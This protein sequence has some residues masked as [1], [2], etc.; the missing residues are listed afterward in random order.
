MSRIKKVLLIL[1]MIIT[2]FIGICIVGNKEI[3]AT[4]TKISQEL[5]SQ[6]VSSL[7]M[8]GFPHKIATFTNNGYSLWCIQKGVGVDKYMTVTNAVANATGSSNSLPTTSWSTAEEL[9]RTYYNSN[10]TRR[11][12][13]KMTGEAYSL[14]YTLGDK[15]NAQENQ[16]SLYVFTSS[17]DDII[18]QC[19]SWKTRTNLKHYESTGNHQEYD[20]YAEE[21]GGLA[22]EYEKFYYLTHNNNNND[23]NQKIFNYLNKLKNTNGDIIVKSQDNKEELYRI[24]AEEYK[25]I[26]KY[27]DIIEVSSKYSKI[28]YKENGTQINGEKYDTYTYKDTI[29][30][31]DRKNNYYILGPFNVDY[32]LNDSSN[33]EL[34]Y[35]GIKDITVYNQKMED[36]TSDK[37]KGDFHIVYDYDGDLDDEGII[38][39]ISYL[40][41]EESSYYFV[42]KAEDGSII[43]YGSNEYDYSWGSHNVGRKIHINN[44][45]YT[46]VNDY[47]DNDSATYDEH[48]YQTNNGNTA[49]FYK[50]E[51]IIIN[52]ENYIAKEVSEDENKYISVYQNEN[53]KNIKFNIFIDKQQGKAT[54]K[55]NDEEL[56]FIEKV[57]GDDNLTFIFKDNQDIE[58]EIIIGLEYSFINLN[59][60]IYKEEKLENGTTQYQY[61]DEQ[62]KITILNISYDVN[63]LKNNNNIKGIE[64]KITINGV[65][66]TKTKKTID[67]HPKDYYT[68]DKVSSNAIMVDKNGTG[69][70]IEDKEYFADNKGQ[71]FESG[72]Y[73]YIVVDRSK[74][75]AEDFKGFYVKIDFIYLDKIEGE[76]YKVNPTVTEYSYEH[77]ADTCDSEFCFYI[78]HTYR[79]KSKTITS[80]SA[81]T[82]GAYKEGTRYYKTYSI[83]L[84]SDRNYETPEI[85]I[86]KKADSGEALYG[87]KFNVRLDINGKDIFGN[88]VIKKVTIPTGETNQEGK[89][90]ITTGLLENA[91]VN[92]E[93]FYG[94]VKVSIEETQV[95][96]GFSKA[97]NQTM[98]IEFRGQAGRITGV[99]GN[100]NAKWLSEKN[101]ASITIYNTPEGKAKIQISKVN[102]SN[103]LIDKAY[104]NIQVAYT[105]PG[106]SEVKNDKITKYGNLIDKKYNVIKGQTT[107]GI[108]SITAQDF[109]KLKDFVNTSDK[110]DL[111]NYTGKITLRIVEVGFSSGYSITSTNKVITLVYINGELKEYT[112]NTN[113]NVTV[114]YLYDILLTEVNKLAKLNSNTSINNAL[115]NIKNSYV[116]DLLKTWLRKDDNKNLSYKDAFNWLSD[117]LKEN[118]NDKDRKTGIMEVTTEVSPDVVEIVV[119]DYSG[120]S[121][122]SSGGSSSNDPDP[123]PD[124]NELLMTVA[125]RV[126]LDQTTK[127]VSANESDGLL[128]TG[129]ELLSGVQ[130]TLRLVKDGS[131]AKLVQ[132]SGKIRTNPTITDSNGYYE[133]NGT[134]PFEEYYVEFKYNGIEYTNTT[135]SREKYNE[136]NWAIS[137]KGSELDTERNTLNNK[138][139]E[140]GSTGIYC[141]TLGKY[142]IPYDYYTIEGIYVEIAN[143]V[144]SHIITDK[145]YPDMETIY[146]EVI[147]NHQKDDSE[148]KSKIDYIKSSMINSYAGYYS[149]DIIKSKTENGT[150]PHTDVRANV[151]W[152][153]NSALTNASGKSYPY[154]GQLVTVLGDGQR[155]INLGLKER[156]STDLSLL[157]DIVETKVSMNGYDT[158]YGMNQAVSSYNQYIYE[159][160]YNYKGSK[161]NT[162]SLIS[163]GVAYYTD[164]EIEYYITYEIEVNNA[165]LTETA[166]T[167]IVDYYN[168]NFSWK[169]SYTTSKGN[170]IKGYRAFIDGDEVSTDI[171]KIT[172]DATGEGRYSGTIDNTNTKYENGKYKKLFI[173]F[174][175]KDETDKDIWLIDG[176]TLTIYLTFQMGQE[177]AKGIIEGASSILYDNIHT[178]NKTSGYSQ[179]WQIGNYAEINGYKTKGGYLDSDSR[180]GNFDIKKYEEAKTAYQEAYSDYVSDTKNAD[181]ARKLKFALGNLTDAREDDAWNVGLNLANTG[182]VRALTGSVWEAISE[183]KAN[184]VK[185]STDLQDHQGNHGLLT[186]V[187]EYGLEGITV[188]LVELE[189]GGVQ[190]VRAKTETHANGDYIFKSYIPGNYTVRFTYGEDKNIRGKST[191]S[192]GETLQVNGQYYQST[193]ANPT[194]DNTKYWYAKDEENGVHPSIRYSDAYDDVL[195]RVNQF[196][197]TI[198][199]TNGR[200]T[201]SDY[202]YDGV[203]EVESYRHK[204]TIYAY[205]STLNLEVEYISPEI[206]GNQANSDYKYEVTNV[207]FGLTPRA[208]ADL[209]LDKYVS[210]IKI[211]L[212]DG[213]L[214]LDANM[215]KEGNVTYLN[216]QI[217]RNAVIPIPKDANALLNKDGLIEV[218]YDDTLLNGATLEVTYT[219]TVSNDGEYDTI[220]YIYGSKKDE[221]GKDVPIAIAYYGEDYKILPSFE[222]SYSVYPNYTGYNV[223]VYHNGVDGVGNYSLEKYEKETPVKVRTAATNIVDYIDP[224]LNFTQTDYLGNPINTDWETTSTD[225]F[226]TERTAST[227]DLNNE[228]MSKYTTIIRATS[229]NVLHTELLPVK[230]QAEKITVDKNST[231]EQKEKANVATTTLTLSKLL[232]TSSTGTNDWIYSNLAEI[233]SIHNDVGRVT[234]I[235]GYDVEGKS[236]PETSTKMNISVINEKDT[237]YPTLET[238][239]SQTITIHPRTG[240][241]ITEEAQSN[242]IIILAV[243]V[244]LA[245]GIVLIKK[246]V[247]TKKE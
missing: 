108:L 27:K 98:T 121:G 52:N 240:L 66:Y 228:I 25:N 195:S 217:F 142:I 227:L 85:E 104:F 153:A 68:S 37:I 180:P 209:D 26:H 48:K 1:A 2:V 241:S 206:K 193:K 14:T 237:I 23:Y 17:F 7:W 30:E 42:Y 79:L 236:Q 210:N 160:D 134:D 90:N 174:N 155:Q 135:S 56:I 191:T 54:Y 198:V 194:T 176:K 19:A 154:A 171:Y 166:L 28:D 157:T 6:D 58:Y 172:I 203:L 38:N 226:N 133:F 106:K 62:G 40:D 140:V 87:A 43:P 35:N 138:Y 211:Y 223:I 126:F 50:R 167:E 12:N 78:H 83:V 86:Y 132:E 231:A 36:I 143:R 103:A 128:G 101:K 13:R 212:S 77:E 51:K 207:D 81:Q 112:Q 44:I 247:L 118:D 46:E 120:S 235:E 76:L 163:D 177:T 215:D 31:I 111:E 10:Y 229:G 63:D 115:N 116:R 65:T 245:T 152:L 74:M 131:I 218:L 150:Y 232:Q 124:K 243:L 165:T 45:Q 127:K 57:S 123:V 110:F 238:A 185:T 93:K 200:S 73:F 225:V 21:Y 158:T 61:T 84:T 70:K 149:S 96:S 170:T 130:V 95:P 213:T 33:Y 114:Q 219:M 109:E 32:K 9:Y 224:N 41:Q 230:D 192:V 122:G 16:A 246:F 202:E 147:A 29:I 190:T 125:G 151:R 187:K 146:S 208:N 179:I 3:N 189:K 139:S 164:D 204:D 205:T 156:D 182:Y 162:G 184:K 129:E 242:T 183:D 15:L 102:S 244:I 168:S 145:R 69:T 234:D 216:D 105:E 18:K 47:E 186:Y 24:T 80:A 55:I 220:K 71:G 233:T 221:N 137:S 197:R 181:K 175:K 119:K 72:R 22:N 60:K 161:K 91:G 239:K 100:S 34:K 136:G 88:S 75:K 5:F 214:Q 222:S 53:G 141:S 82:L 67:V 49:I 4:Q 188:E 169:N 117:F 59:G 20:T 11:A 159:E 196:N 8:T 39:K 89:I 92:L 99:T 199:N 178:E 144:K 94:T 64:D 113:Q 173:E 97:Q 107:N 148:I 201:S